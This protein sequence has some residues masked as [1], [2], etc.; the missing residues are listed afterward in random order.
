MD[1]NLEI[2][3]NNFREVD[4]DK[5]IG[6]VITSTEPLVAPPNKKRRVES[7][8]YSNVIL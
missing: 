8:K 5:L 6:D 7:K 3:D 2:P 4:V 1:Q